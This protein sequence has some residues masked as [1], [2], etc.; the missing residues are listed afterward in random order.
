MNVI[1]VA[2][3]VETTSFDK[4][5]GD[6]LS[7]ALVEVLE[8]YTLG[9]EA[10]FHSRPRSSKY[11]SSGAQEIHGISYWKA[12]EFPEPKETS[13]DILNWLAPLQSIFPL[14]MIYHANGGFDFK[15]LESH[16]RKDDLQG[17]F[18]KAFDENR[19]ISTLKLSRQNLKNLPNHKLSTVAKHYNLNLNHHEAL[20]DTRV[21][22]Q[23]YCKIMKGEDIW[24]GRLL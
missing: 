7:C 18:Y 15:W 9:R 8:D 17:S 21:C 1:A 16:F 5:G 14:Q 22:A 11:F 13:I 10:L 19:L 6:I 4:I 2:C 12:Q 20:S 23:I 3:D 24:T